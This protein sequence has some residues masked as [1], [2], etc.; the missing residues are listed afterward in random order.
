MI[1]AESNPTSHVVDQPYFEIFESLHWKIWLPE[2]GSFALTKFMVLQVLGSLILL[3]LFVPLAKRIRH[4]EAPRGRLWNALE[5]LL[6]FIRN[7][8][9]RPSIGKEEAD[10]YVPF[11]W[12]IFFFILVCNLMGL[13]PFLGSPTGAITVTGVLALCS[14]VVIHSVPIIR[15]GPLGYLQTF[16]P[17]IELNS[18]IMWVL[19]PF[20]IAMMFVIELIGA[21]VRAIVL[22]IRLFA[23]MFAGHTVLAAILSFIGVAGELW[24]DGNLHIAGFVSITVID[25]VVA[26]ALSV[27][28]L[29]IA[30]LQA[31]IFT[32]LTAMFIG[33]ALHPHH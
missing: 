10:R 9:A 14:F 30:F 17:P 8:V 21:F 18:P 13:V 25:L 12:T 11:L 15:M 20:I 29:G 33:M 2:F 31:F 3:G 28:E 5:F 26:T 6:V 1:I 16:A 27:L 24:N 22:A 4:G 19:G 23:N 7:D 32:L